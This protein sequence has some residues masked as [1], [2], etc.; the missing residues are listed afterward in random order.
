MNILYD[1]PFLSKIKTWDF[2]CMWSRCL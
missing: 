1:K 2:R